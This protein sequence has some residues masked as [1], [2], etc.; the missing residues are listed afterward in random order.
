[1]L[2]RHRNTRLWLTRK[3]VISPSFSNA[4]LHIVTHCARLMDMH[5]WQPAQVKN[6]VHTV[7]IGVQGTAFIELDEPEASGME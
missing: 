5:D 3:V 4:T 7:S 6:S 1:M 2:P